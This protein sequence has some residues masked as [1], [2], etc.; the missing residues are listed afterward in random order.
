MRDGWRTRGTAHVIGHDV[1]HDG[2]IMPREMISA[3]VTDPEKLI[4]RLFE[5]YDPK[6]LG[7]LKPGD[8]IVAGRNL[9]CGK[10]H[11]GG[12][13]AMEAMGLRILCESMPGTIVRA[14]IGLALPCMHKC[15]GILD[16]IKDGDQIEADYESGEVINL[17]SGERRMFSPMQ[18][19]ARNMV[20]RGGVKGI[21]ADWLE[22]HPE[23][24]VPL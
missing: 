9:G 11:T 2:P 7:R 12:Y 4:R 19:E 15:E 20:A 22:K 6:L 3:R 18:E 14:T 24:A 1:E 8:F 23:F 10:P 17:T 5:E 16:F 21:L 13:I